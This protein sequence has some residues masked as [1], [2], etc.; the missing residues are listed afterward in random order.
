M[1]QTEKKTETKLNQ[2][3]REKN[4]QRKTIQY[5][6]TETLNNGEQHAHRNNKQKKRI[7]NAQE[8]RKNAIFQTD[9]GTECNYL[10]GE[11]LGSQFYCNCFVIIIC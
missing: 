7:G 1:K 8:E 3:K 5:W 9:R 2:Q 10:S 6:N 4:E 11:M